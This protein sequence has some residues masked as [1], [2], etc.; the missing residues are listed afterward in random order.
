MVAQ[1]DMYIQKARA[2][3]MEALGRLARG[4]AHDLGQILASIEGQALFLARDMG[5]PDAQKEIAHSILHAAGQAQTLL[6]R[7]RAFARDAPCA[8][9][10]FDMGDVARSTLLLMRGSIPRN[11]VVEGDIAEGEAFMVRGHAPQMRQLALNIAL[12]ARDAMKGTGGALILHLCKTRSEAVWS[13]TDLLPALPRPS[14]LYPICI[15][16]PVAGR[17]CLSLGD[18]AAGRIYACLSIVDTGIGIGREDMEHLFEPFFTTKLP[19]EGT[20]LGLSTVHGIL[21]AHQGALTID[22][23]LERG[24]RFDVYLPL[25]EDV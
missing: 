6:A 18:L 19:E 3:K 15:E 24:T 7:I 17:V 14:D 16:E 1:Q 13:K 8:Y 10:P 21:T 22:S 25:V 9:T 4:I 5:P 2:Q 23:T 11:V 20:G 12:N